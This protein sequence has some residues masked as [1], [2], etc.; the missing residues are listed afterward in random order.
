M[1][2][3]TNFY[4]V[5]YSFHCANSKTYIYFEIVFKMLFNSIYFPSFFINFL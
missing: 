4:G 1:S 3:K 5:E 2:F